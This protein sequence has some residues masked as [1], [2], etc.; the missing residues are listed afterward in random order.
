MLSA[1]NAL[2]PHLIRMH[3]G[4]DSE[5]RLG[6]NVPRDIAELSRERNFDRTLSQLERV[7]R[8]RLRSTGLAQTRGAPCGFRKNEG[9][10]SVRC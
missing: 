7:Q 2:G 9:K 4:Y 8:M 1:F 5:R 6:A 10:G 3:R